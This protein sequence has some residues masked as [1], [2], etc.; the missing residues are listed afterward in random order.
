MSTE[1]QQQTLVCA[2]HLSLLPV[3]L[4]K[5]LELPYVAWGLSLQVLV[6]CLG[7]GSQGW[8]QEALMLVIS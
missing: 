7:A 6:C 2:T 8:K 4:G 5:N 1:L 3:A